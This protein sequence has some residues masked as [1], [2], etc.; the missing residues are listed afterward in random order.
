MR[1]MDCVSRTFH[2]RHQRKQPHKQ[3][4]QVIFERVLKLDVDSY[5]E[6]F[7]TSVPIQMVFDFTEDLEE[8]EQ[9]D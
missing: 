4:V 6:N 9:A 1:A 3:F 2:H 8:L 7:N 5:N